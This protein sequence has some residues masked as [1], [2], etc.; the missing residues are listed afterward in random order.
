M[1]LSSSVG[2]VT[3]LG[4]GRISLSLPLHPPPQDQC[5]TCSQDGTC[6]A[7]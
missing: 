7:Q 5:N 6:Y 2:V 4:H 3:Q 1:V